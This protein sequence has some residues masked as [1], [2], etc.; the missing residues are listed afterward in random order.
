[1]DSF[2]ECNAGADFGRQGFLELAE[3]VAG[4]GECN[5][6][7]TEFAE[8]LV[9]FFTEILL[10]HGGMLARISTRCCCRC[11]GRWMV[12]V[13]VFIIHP[14]TFLHVP[15]DVSPCNSF[16]METGSRH[17]G[18]SRASSGRKTWY[19]AS[20][21]MRRT[22]LRFMVP[23]QR[24]IKSSTN[25]SMYARSFLDVGRQGSLQMGAVRAVCR[26]VFLEEAVCKSVFLEVYPRSEK[27]L[28]TGV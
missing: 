19:I 14:N 22:R 1:M 17:V 27:R 21:R 4:A 26:G 3:E 23:W 2:F 18:L 25:T 6:H 15:H 7:G 24:A 13:V 28:A 9:P 11:S 10:W 16:L 8:H 20:K 5:I 12:I